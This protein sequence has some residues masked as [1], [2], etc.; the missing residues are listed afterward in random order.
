M[1]LRWEP[2]KAQAGIT[3]R[4]NKQKTA[5]VVDDLGGRVTWSLGEWEGQGRTELHTLLVLI[6]LRALG[7]QDRTSIR[8]RT[9]WTYATRREGIV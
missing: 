5:G 6:A 4:Q 2:T 8:Q 7:S 1:G 3:T 9:D